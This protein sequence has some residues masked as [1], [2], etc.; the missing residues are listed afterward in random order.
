MDVSNKVKLCAAVMNIS[1]LFLVLQ[2]VIYREVT[3]RLSVSSKKKHRG[4]WNEMKVSP[5]QAEIF[6]IMEKT[7]GLMFSLVRRSSVHRLRRIAGFRFS[8]LILSK[9]ERWYETANCHSMSQN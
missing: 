3:Q 2:L 1:E 4:K 8:E 9:E 6:T 5:Q 7:N